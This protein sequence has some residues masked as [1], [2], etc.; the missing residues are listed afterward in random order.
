LFYRRKV[1]IG[2]KARKGWFQFFAVIWML[3]MALLV[4]GIAAGLGTDSPVGSGSTSQSEASLALVPGT[5]PGQPQAMVAAFND[6]PWTGSGLGVSYSTNGGASWSYQNL[7]FPTYVGPTCS[8]PLNPACAVPLNVQMTSAFDP[9]VAADTQGNFYVAQISGQA[10]GISGLYVYKSTNSGVT[11]QTP[12]PVSQDGA[13]ASNPDPTYRYNDRDQITV[14]RFSGSPHTNNIYATWIKDRGY[15]SSMPYGDI[16]FAYST[17]GG[18]SFNLATGVTETMP[19]WSGIAFPGRINDAGVGHDMGNMPVPA[20]ASDGTIYVSWMDYNV[21]TGGAGTIYLD[22]STDGGITW[23]QDKL[24]TSVNLPPLNVSPSGA[25]A[26]GAPVLKV[27][28][29][30]PSILYLVYAEDPDQVVLPDGTISNGPDEADIHFIKSTNG[31]NTWTAPVRVNDD[32]PSTST[33][34]QILPWMDVKADGTIDIAWYDDR[35]SYS[36]P[37]SWWKIYV[38]K[39]VD[40]GAT[41]S[42]NQSVNDV[43]FT[44]ST[45]GEYP[46]LAVDSVNMYVAWTTTAYDSAGD[47]YFDNMANSAL[48]NSGKPLLSLN[49]A[50]PF[51][52]SYAD[53]TTGLLSVTFTIQNNGADPATSVAITGSTATNSVTSSTTMPVSVGTVA[54]GS[55]QTFTLQYSVPAGVGNF[56]ATVNASADDPCSNTYTYP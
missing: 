16:Y 2:M 52:A 8:D 31:G 18:A 23:G 12:V 48:C 11:W 19:P 33:S 14:D 29:S 3:S 30:N 22:K 39:S 42:T 17:N 47:I 43:N 5:T 56:R 51:W 13:A 49:S 26:K 21:Q 4:T 54:A 28:P 53:Y 32:P 34:D 45:L 25:L 37:G 20:V 55:S 46:G 35:Y 36:P 24:V 1:M 41:F 15:N 10:G 40:G 27:S 9:S 6:D 7:T 38:T 44:A 50:T